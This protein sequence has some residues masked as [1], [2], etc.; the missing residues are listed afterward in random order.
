MTEHLIFVGGL[1]N[2]NVPSDGVSAKNQILLRELNKFF[3]KIITIDTFKWKKRPLVLL[4][5]FYCL[6]IYKKYDIILSLNN[7]N[8]Y[9]LI[10]IIN[11]VHRK[12][13]IFYWTIGGTIGEQIKKQIFKKRHYSMITHFIVEGDL[14]KNTLNEMGFSN[15]TVI[16]NF[17]PIEYVP[18]KKFDDQIIKFV[19][20][21]RIMPEK[22][23][24]YILDSAIRLNE[25][26][27]VQKFTI[28][29]YG[30]I[31]DDYCNE[32]TSKIGHLTNASYKGNLDLLRPSG[33]DTL[34]GYDVFLFP[35]YWD[36]EGF[37]GVIAYAYMAGLPI[38]ASDW[39]MNSELIINEKTGLIIPVHDVNAL[40][41]AMLRFIDKD[42][43]LL[44]LS[45][46]CLMH[47]QSFSCNNLIN[48]S[49]L[50]TIG[51]L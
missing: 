40:L 14:I 34:S 42:I 6:M 49:T 41:Q 23:C 15:V 32:F 9:R 22:G 11:L 21:S 27:Y 13:K 19:F 28:D 7:R 44:E 36:G 8:A 26:N 2:G 33:F 37:A 50:Q 51:L 30:I 1:D 12:R 29:F 35:T 31:D 3:K 39:N 45:K 17:N 43:Y 38:I 4:N 10:K 47:S 16:S 48:K 5:I 24:R 46:N 18:I 20:L 25:L